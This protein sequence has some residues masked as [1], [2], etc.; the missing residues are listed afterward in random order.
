MVVRFEDHSGF[1]RACGLLALGAG[2]MAAVLPWTVPAAA[3]GAALALGVGPIFGGGFRRRWIALVAA[4]ALLA[5]EGALAPT[6][7]LSLVQGGLFALLLAA[8]RAEGARQSG[9]RPP[10]PVAVALAIALCALASFLAASLLPALAETLG[11]AAPAW[12]ARAQ[13][14]ALLG[15][16]VGLSAAPL[17]LEVGGDA[18]EAK[19]LSLRASL[20]VELRPLAERAVAAS[21]GACAGLPEGARADLRASVGALAMAALDLSARCADLGRAASPAVEEELERRCAALAAGAEAAQDEAARQSYRRAAE[22]LAGQMEHLRRV[23][24]ARERA[25]ARLHED[26]ANL[27]RAR[28]SL[29]LLRGAENAGEL[30]LLQQRLEQGTL[31]FEQAVPLPAPVREGA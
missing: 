24:R 28:F 30:D 21:R 31:V 18:V 13:C 27:E 6:P 23:L 10:M 16:W 7:W 5:V 4:C 9:A 3:V 2:A 8:V 22:A 1:Q 19:L 26:V 15:F 11:R 14:G 29:T 20:G 12:A 17:H 25:L